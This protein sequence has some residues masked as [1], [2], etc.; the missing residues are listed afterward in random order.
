MSDAQL[1]PPHSA[2]GL[3]PADSDGVVL[4][5]DPDSTTGFWCV[6]DRS[7]SSAKHFVA[8]PVVQGKEVYLGRFA[9]AEAAALVIARRY[10][11]AFYE[12]TT[13]PPP[14]TT[15]DEVIAAAA[16][17]GLT[18][19]TADN[20]SGYRGV[21]A[22]SQRK[23]FMAEIPGPALIL[24]DGT[25]I[26]RVGNF[27]TAHEA[28]LAIARRLGPDESAR[29]GDEKRN[30]AGWVISDQPAMTP[31]EALQAAAS[32]GLTLEPDRGSNTAQKTAY[33]EVFRSSAVMEA[34]YQALIAHYSIG[35]FASPEEAALMRARTLRDDPDIVERNLE[36]SRMCK[37]P[38]LADEEPAEHEADSSIGS[39]SATGR[40]LRVAAQRKVFDVE[41]VPV[42]VDDDDDGDFIMVRV[43]HADAHVDASSEEE[44]QMVQSEAVVEH[45]EADDET[46]QMV[47]M[48]P[49][50]FAVEEALLQ[51]EEEG[52]TLQSSNNR[53][54]LKGVVFRSGQSRP[55]QAQG[56]RDGKTVHLGCFATAEEAA[57]TADETLP[58]GLPLAWGRLLSGPKFNGAVNAQ[59]VGNVPLAMLSR[60]SADNPH[61]LPLSSGA[62]S[63]VASDDEEEMHY[64][65]ELLALPDAILR[66]KLS[67]VG[68]DASGDR[69]ALLHAVAS[70]IH[71]FGLMQVGLVD[72]DEEEESEREDEEDEETVAPPPQMFDAFHMEKAPGETD[73]SVLQLHIERHFV[74]LVKDCETSGKEYIVSNIKKFE[75]TL[76]VYHQQTKALNRA[77]LE[78]KASLLY[79][80][81]E[82]VRAAHGEEILS[83]D[84]LS[85]V[86]GGRVV[87]RL[88]LGKRVL[89]I[90]HDHQ[91]FRVKIEPA[92]PQLA[93]AY[94]KLTQLTE[95]LKSVTKL[96]GV[97]GEKARAEATKVAAATAHLPNPGDGSVGSLAD[98]S[99]GSCTASA[100]SSS[101]AQP[102]ATQRAS[103]QDLEERASVLEILRQQQAH[104]EQ[105]TRQN[106][107]IMKELGGLR[108]WKAHNQHRVVTPAF[109][110]P[111]PPTAPAPSPPPPAP[112]GTPAAAR[113]SEEDG[114]WIQAASAPPPTP[115]ALPVPRA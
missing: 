102:Q 99:V 31:D 11:T 44:A 28:A 60:V 98:D 23:T 65:P 63:D 46:E 15:R 91:R 26:K 49:Q 96:R 76:G 36:R 42:M 27:P 112:D 79:E 90:Q 13:T 80:N 51:Q 52:L 100:C 47:E 64:P 12:Q 113:W 32:E 10:P 21:G 71:R 114:H 107:R 78:L 94:P 6:H 111:P 115:S 34:R 1:S 68:V 85:K 30:R 62:E 77:P 43:A 40:P 110:A 24:S 73:W 33:Y 104:I 70:N 18:L 92:D 38:K 19:L 4:A 48:A 103:S 89:S 87:V 3:A 8:K 29:R 45:E 108:A 2:L 74:H 56:S 54:G 57:V 9:S 58:G 41:A 105:L 95:P 75:L 35:C 20:A 16:A 109:A 83:G 14:A 72:D 59:V 17:E 7:T 67:E 101:E 84:V 66:N 93:K 106:G 97:P 5:R 53:A 61:S 39:S 25:R 69:S 86:Q 88:Q 50:Q 37:R 55:Y 81:L 22:N 82:A